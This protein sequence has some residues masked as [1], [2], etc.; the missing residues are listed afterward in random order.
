VLILVQQI[1]SNGDLVCEVSS[2]SSDALS[3]GL[4][5]TLCQHGSIFHD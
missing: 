4:E 1:D 5:L 2:Y 3:M